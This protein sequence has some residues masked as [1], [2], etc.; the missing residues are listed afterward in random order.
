MIY[1]FYDFSIKLTIACAAEQE[2]L[3]SLFSYLVKCKEDDKD[4]QLLPATLTR[5]ALH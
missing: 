5:T 1:I 2:A 3:K 4:K